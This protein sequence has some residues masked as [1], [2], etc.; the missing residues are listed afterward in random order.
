MDEH[1][2]NEELQPEERILAAAIEEFTT[3]GYDGTRMQ[4][5]ADRAGI[6]KSALHYYFRHKE[7]LFKLV[8]DE[9]VG[10]TLARLRF[11]IA[12]LDSIQEKLERG[13]REYY[14][15]INKN[16]KVVRFLFMEVYRNPD[17]IDRFLEESNFRSWIDGLNRELEQEYQAGRIHQI[18]AEQL[19]LNMV[20]MCIFPHLGEKIIRK[21]MKLSNKEY[22]ELLIEREDIILEFI[23]R[24]LIREE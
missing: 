20:S 16:A 6:S 24:A 12:G 9:T 17:L 14:R 23:Q 22:G 11:D 13:F 15:A 4:S 1:K 3:K 7:R 19:I 8:L 2:N 5:I 18:R 21:V 10:K